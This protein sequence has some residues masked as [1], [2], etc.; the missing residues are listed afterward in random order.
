[1]SLF[2]FVENVG[3][4]PWLGRI[5]SCLA[6]RNYEIVCLALIHGYFLLRKEPQS[7]GFSYKI[8]WRL[9]WA[10]LSLFYFT[11]RYIRS[12]WYFWMYLIIRN[13][14]N[15]RIRDPSW[16]NNLTFNTVYFTIS[17]TWCIKNRQERHISGLSLWMETQLKI[18]N[19]RYLICFYVCTYTNSGRKGNRLKSNL[20]ERKL[21]GILIPPEKK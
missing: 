3:C 7:T 9:L 18:M 11:C 12:L 19:V 17:W 4:F 21:Q 8:L 6:D 5:Y 15:G 14:L 1:M 10:K 2:R 16:T 20:N 13:I